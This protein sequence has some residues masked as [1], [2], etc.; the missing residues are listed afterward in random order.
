MND[1]A[2]QN[3]N[4]VDL[5]RLAASG[6]VGAFEALYRANVGRVH[7][8]CLRMVGDRTEAEELTQDVFVRAWER[9]GSFRRESGFATW[10]QRVAVNV[11]LDA[12]RKRSRWRE[13]FTSSA[14][15]GALPGDTETQW[16]T[17]TLRGRDGV[18]DVHQS[19][20]AILDER[21]DE[22]PADTWAAIEEN[23]LLI[24]RALMEIHLAMERHPESHVLGLL[25][26]ETYRREADLLDQVRWWSRAP[27]WEPSLDPE[28]GPGA[29]VET[30]S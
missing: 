8:L 19:L 6:D 20:I 27:A 18:S 7:A 2:T 3:A 23:L 29:P 15:P 11:V 12:L 21:R 24:D 30:K 26:A 28:P 17:S 5:V 25:L 9:L 22:L 14:D 4:E 10:L 1:S 13:R 16:I